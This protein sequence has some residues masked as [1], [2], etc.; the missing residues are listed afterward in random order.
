MIISLEEDGVLRVYESPEAAVGAVEALDAE[1][2]FQTVYDDVGQPYAIRWD[3]PNSR[4]GVGP[5]QLVGSGEYM[6]VPAGLPDPTALVALIQ[7]AQH[8]EPADA[9]ASLR[10]IVARFTAL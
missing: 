10:A 7:R 5:L 4:V 6:L 8:V 9:K 1:S 2:T 3:R